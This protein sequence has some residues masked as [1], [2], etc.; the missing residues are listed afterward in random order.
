M[1]FIGRK[2]ELEKL[3]RAMQAD[4]MN[5]SLIYGRR[6]VGK[7]ELV[8]QALSKIRAKKL[9]Y[10]CKQVAEG[11]NVNGLSEILSESMGLPKLAFSSMES[12]L[13]Y[14]FE[15]SA[16]EKIILVLDEY[17]YLRES[18]KGMD[19]ILQAMIDKHRK[20]SK[21]TLILLGSYVEVMR[22]LLEHENPLY[23]RVDLTIYLKQMDYYESSLFYPGYSAEDKVRIYSVFGGIPY[24]NRLVDDSKSVKENMIDLIA[25]PGARLENEVSMYLNAELSKIINAN[26]VFEA[27]SRGFSRYSDILAQSHVSSGPTLADVLDKLIRMEVVAKTSPMNDRGNKK[28]MAYHICDNLSLF[29]YRYI[30][31]YSS[32]MN[33]MNSEVFYRKY[34][35]KD[36]EEQY[37][38]HLFE[39]IC[40]Q[41]LI[42]KNKKGE[43]EPVIEKIGQYYYDNPAERSNGEFDIVTQDELGYTFYEVKFK[44]KPVSDEM[45]DEEIAQVK[46]TGLDCY[47]YVFFSRSGFHC[48]KRE[49]VKLIDLKELFAE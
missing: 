24:Y 27:L 39:N 19:S 29:Y 32:Q 8:S 33:I 23:G 2:E 10:E 16:K 1:N 4:G 31:K 5:F 34:I 15:L 13:D 21:I 11:S 47:K 30:F 38:P 9:Y 28:K 44:K 12:L 26:E 37:G 18:I 41:Y 20:K 22:S 42:R 7:S 14:I 17:P 48:K 3:N 36:F 49:N 46:A 25:S 45:I 40:K 6:R 43:I 35:E